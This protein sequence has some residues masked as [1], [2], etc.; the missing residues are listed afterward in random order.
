MRR[1]ILGGA[2][3]VIIA[4]ALTLISWKP[5][6]EK[7]AQYAFKSIDSVGNDLFKTLYDSVG[8]AETGLS[9]PLFEKAVTG[10]YNL[11]NDGKTATD[12]SILT[13]ADFDQNS[14]EKRLWIIDLDKK[15]LI[16]NTWV[17]H[18]EFSGAD[19]ATNFSNAVS[20][21]KSSIGFY[22]TGETYYGKHG[23]SLRLDGMDE[24]FNSNAR[25]RAIVVHGASYVSQGTINAL[26]RLGRSQGC[27]A[28]PQ[29]QVK[30]VVAAM[31][32]KTVLFI[33]NTEQFYTSKYLNDTEPGVLASK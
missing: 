20:S 4:L 15:E 10:F 11:K 5:I 22:I 17:A 19:K 14:T 16:L 9:F 6:E 1:R 32:G 12:K 31:G 3:L 21:F 7:P 33:N 27:P 28:V 30:T 13:I 8:L 26:G 25:K 29:N 2:G 24:D 18:G 23:L